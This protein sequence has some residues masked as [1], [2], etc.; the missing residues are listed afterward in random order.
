MQEWNRAARGT[1]NVGPHHESRPGADR[2]PI[3]ANHNVGYSDFKL[4]GLIFRQT[5][6]NLAVPIYCN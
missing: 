6:F 4:A 2:T 1:D 5:V 3:D